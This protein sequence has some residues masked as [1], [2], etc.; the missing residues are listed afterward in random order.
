MDVY[1][2]THPKWHFG[3]VGQG[4]ESPKMESSPKKYDFL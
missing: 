2:T 3:Q 4:G 1:K